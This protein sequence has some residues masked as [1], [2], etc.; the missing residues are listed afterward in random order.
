MA[1]YLDY[2]Q[3]KGNI[4]LLQEQSLCCAFAHIFLGKRQK[5]DPS[6]KLFFFIE[7]TNEGEVGN[8]Q[9]GQC[10]ICFILE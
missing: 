8:P 9:R 2:W 3:A 6:E 5:G 10:S 4:V 1:D 7:K